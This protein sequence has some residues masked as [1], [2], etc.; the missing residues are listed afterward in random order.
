MKFTFSIVLIS[1]LSFSFI[2]SNSLQV[3]KNQLT[4]QEFISFFE[5]RTNP[6]GIDKEIGKKNWIYVSS[7][8]HG[9]TQVD[10]WMFEIYY[11]DVQYI[12][13]SIFSPTK[14]L[15]TNQLQLHFQHRQAY[16]DFVAQF[17]D[18]NLNQFKQERKEDIF[19]TH[20]KNDKYFVYTII[21]RSQKMPYRVTIAELP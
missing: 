17:V 9:T 2:T 19:I 8:K 11:H 16:E 21:D 13:Q 6:D 7:E 10:M 14:G 5:N 4:I 20:Y 1:F 3:D 12:M 15:K 18:A